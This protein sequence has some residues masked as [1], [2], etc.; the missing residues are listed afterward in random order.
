MSTN[1][2]MMAFT[3]QGDPDPRQMV[4]LMR[5]H[6]RRAARW[7]RALGCEDAWPFFDIAAKVHPE[8]RAPASEV[9]ILEQ[10]LRSL[11]LP[12]RV[13]H[14]CIWALHWDQVKDLP[15]VRRLAL[16]DPFE[17]LLAMFEL[18]GTFTTEHGWGDVG[19]A[20]FRLGRLT[21][22]LDV[23]GDPATPRETTS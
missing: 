7:A 2:P 5:E 17:P 23:P 12:S 18:G 16:P 13:V 6:L 10:R 8:T 20:A 15:A 4:H 19:G 21:D 9:T 22:H 14:A 3:W 1:T 11:H